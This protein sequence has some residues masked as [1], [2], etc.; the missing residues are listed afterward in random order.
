[1]ENYRRRR[2]DLEK[3]LRELQRQGIVTTPLSQ[4]AQGEMIAFFQNEL[5]TSTQILTLF[6]KKDLTLEG[7]RRMIDEKLSSKPK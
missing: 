6:D 3:A 7:V 1:M 4:T 2:K 5:L